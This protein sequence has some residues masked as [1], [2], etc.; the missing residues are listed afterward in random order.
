MNRRSLVKSLLRKNI[1][2]TTLSEN[3]DFG[4]TENFIL[5]H[6]FK[7]PKVYTWAEKDPEKREEIRKNALKNFPNKLPKCNW[8]AFQIRVK[9]SHFER[10]LDIENIPKLII[11]AF[12]REMIYRDKSRYASVCLYPDDDL[13]YVR[14]VQINADFSDDGTNATEV[15]IFGKI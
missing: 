14:C 6:H 5:I 10:Q 1:H 2:T 3:L 12:S 13:R 15:W 8:Y 11:D 4:N 9:R 7:F